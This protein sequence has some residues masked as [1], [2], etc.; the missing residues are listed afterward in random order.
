M[1]H[2]SPHTTYRPDIDGLRAVAALGVVIFHIWP[3][4]LR[5]GYV[6]VDVFFVISGYLISSIILKGV[7][8]G[9]FSLA[10]FY[11]RRARRIFPALIVV[12]LFSFAV[13]WYVLLPHEFDHLNR[14]IAAGAGFVS[15]LL[16]WSEGGYFDFVAIKK[17][18][19]HLWS[20]GIEEQF[21][22]LWPLLLV[23]AHRF[24]L[25]L[26]WTIIVIALIS[27]ALN[28]VLVEQHPSASFYLPFARFWELLGG[29]AIAFI[30]QRR[31]AIISAAWSEARARAISIVGLVM[32]V[33]AMALYRDLPTFPGWWPLLPVLGAMAMIAAG[34]TAWVNRKLLAHPVAVY[35]GLISYPLYLWHWPIVTFTRIVNPEWINRGSRFLIF[36]A[37]LAA[38][39]LTF[40]FIEGPIRTSA[41]SRKL[42]VTLFGSLLLVA[43]AGFMAWQSDLPPRNNTDV[44]QKIAQATRNFGGGVEAMHRETLYDASVLVQ[45]S[46]HSTFTIFVGDSLMHQYAPRVS[47]QISARPDRTHSAT[48]ATIGGCKPIPDYYNKASTACR[49]M[50][51][52]ALRLSEM[53]DARNVV[54]GAD[55]TDIVWRG[56][57][58]QLMASFESYVRKFAARHPTYILLNGPLGPEFHPEVMLTGTRLKHLGT[59]MAIEPASMAVQLERQSTMRK[60]LTE[61]AHRAGA[62]IID[63]MNDL[64]PD[65]K[66]PVT[67]ANRVPLYVDKT[68]MRPF[69]VVNSA[70]FLDRTYFI[71]GVGSDA[72]TA[73]PPPPRR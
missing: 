3:S 73:A 35:L 34:P 17:P 15:N 54:I 46:Q 27:F 12:L 71:N 20:L 40:R 39:A 24:R 6:G 32:I 16:L 8:Q 36:A 18:L 1:T 22:L 37:S 58:V 33:A 9:T 30:E 45:K 5:G 2:A 7:S 10:D 25:P 63:P 23:A 11:I 26:K 21:Y 14:H 51:E 42:G 65:G 66:C 53:P 72:A 61:V 43:T 48:F 28:V 60:L 55:W 59:E 64:C 44:F 56:N 62:I 29:G 47:A 68:H 57:L 70:R 41:P 4:V 31:G 67:T 19:L 69:H 49:K 50:M 13:G 52:A 38:A